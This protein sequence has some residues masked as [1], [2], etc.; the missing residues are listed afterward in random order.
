MY[1]PLTP[2]RLLDTRF[3]NGLNGKFTNGIVR[4][5]TIAGRGGVPAD[6]V[7]VTG[8][9]TVTGQSSGG[10][11][12]LGPTMTSNPT[13]STITFAVTPGEVCLGKPD[14]LADRQ[15]IHARGDDDVAF[16]Q[17]AGDDD[18]I[19]FIASNCDWPQ[20]EAARLLIEHPDSRCTVLFKH[21]GEGQRDSGAACPFKRPATLMPKRS[22]GG[23]F[24]SVTFTV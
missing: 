11:V 19:C 3:A 22:C 24:F 8:N 9:L 7:A 1:V 17:A 23:G 14:S 15:A 13:T 12:S 5:V 6:A 2:T 10:Y 20:S 16:G 4:T 18:A 21:G